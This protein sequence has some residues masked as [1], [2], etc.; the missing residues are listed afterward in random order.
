[1]PIGPWTP[2]ARIAR[3]RAERQ[4]RAPDVKSRMFWF[5]VTPRLADQLEA[6]MALF[7]IKPS[8]AELVS[9]LLH[10]GLFFR[11][12]HRPSSKPKRRLKREPLPPE[13]RALLES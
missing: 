2:P 6:E 9:Q 7:G 5:R 11:R 1:M 13:L 10:E 12:Q 4:A 8:M 3:L